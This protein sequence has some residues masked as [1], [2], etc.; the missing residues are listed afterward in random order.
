MRP[1]ISSACP[2]RRSGRGFW[3]N[4][5]RYFRLCS[6][7]LRLGAGTD[8][9]PRVQVQQPCGR[10]EPTSESLRRRREG[11]EKGVETRGHAVTLVESRMAVFVGG[12]EIGAVGR[13]R[14]AAANT[15]TSFPRSVTLARL[16][17]CFTCD[18]NVDRCC[19]AESLRLMCGVG[20][21]CVN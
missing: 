7:P 15:W 12:D 14:H 6:S 21:G 8:R 3:F 11:N 16:P 10:I 17:P 1:D 9:V 4:I 20:S 5:C 19:H 18:A 2:S 13:L